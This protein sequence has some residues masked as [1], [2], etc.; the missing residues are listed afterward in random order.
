MPPKEDYRTAERML[1]KRWGGREKQVAMVKARM[2]A[3]E[4][5][6]ASPGSALVSPSLRNK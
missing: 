4:E 6:W 2:V 1:E 5:P 3:V